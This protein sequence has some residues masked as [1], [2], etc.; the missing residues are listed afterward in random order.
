[1]EQSKWL[2]RTGPATTLKLLQGIGYNPE[3]SHLVFSPLAFKLS[4]L[5]MASLSNPIQERDI[6]RLLFDQPVLRSMLAQGFYPG[7]EP[8]KSGK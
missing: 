6:N 5:S 3:V 2:A 7:D 4:L 1:M 8:E